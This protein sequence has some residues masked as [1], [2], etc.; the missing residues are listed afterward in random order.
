MTSLYGNP[1]YDDLSTSSDMSDTPDTYNSMSFPLPDFGGVNETEKD[2]NSPINSIPL[3]HTEAE[4]NN[5]F[6]Y[7]NSDLLALSENLTA[8]KLTSLTYV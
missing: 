5:T 1:P 3:Q 8:D 7:Q 2:T 4:T 6:P